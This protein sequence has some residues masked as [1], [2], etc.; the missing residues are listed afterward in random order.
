MEKYRICPVYENKEF[1]SYLTLS[2]EDYSKIY[3]VNS[4]SEEGY[5]TVFYRNANLNQYIPNNEG[6]SFK[7]DARAGSNE[8]GAVETLGFGKIIKNGVVVAIANNVKIYQTM[9]LEECLR[10]KKSLD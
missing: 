8:P 5:F 9:D 1:P 4:T 2:L 7:L 6:Y 10:L 3:A